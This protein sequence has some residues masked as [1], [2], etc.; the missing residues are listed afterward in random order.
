MVAPAAEY[1]GRVKVRQGLEPEPDSVAGGS[2]REDVGGPVAMTVMA[3]EVFDRLL[4]TL[5]QPDEAP[6]LA[7][8]LATLPRLE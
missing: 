6:E 5:E 2:A 4:A 7:A 8:K 3:P 1:D